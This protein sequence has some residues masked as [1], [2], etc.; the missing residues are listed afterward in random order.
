M[1][2]M[3]LTSLYPDGARAAGYDFGRLVDALVRSAFR[4]AE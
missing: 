1:P 4:R 3:T 2:G